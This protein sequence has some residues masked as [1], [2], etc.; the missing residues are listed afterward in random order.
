MTA[1]NKKWYVGAMNDGL[2]VIDAPPRPSTDDITDQPNVNVIVAMGT[3]REAADLLVA[4]HNK[5]IDDDWSDLPVN[6]RDK[7]IALDVVSGCSNWF[8]IEHYIVPRTTAALTTVRKE[9]RE[10]AWR[11]A[12]Q[13]LRKKAEDY[14][15]QGERWQQNA[16]SAGMEIIR[17]QDYADRD[18]CFYKMAALTTLAIE[19]DEA[20]AN[21]EEGAGNERL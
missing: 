5:R 9:T 20:A 11:D 2:F 12:A 17:Q 18:A 7:A 19:F 8:D 4:E 10:A 15:A 6:E 13:K 1:N 14:R 3:N 16:E 21:T